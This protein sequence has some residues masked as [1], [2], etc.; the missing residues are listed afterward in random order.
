ME[1]MGG[2]GG[3]LSEYVVEKL[4]RD[5]IVTSIWEG[6][7]NIQ[8][9][10]F[11]EVLPRVR[12]AIQEEVERVRDASDRA[13]SGNLKVALDSVM[14]TLYGAQESGTLQY[15]QK[16]IADGFARLMA[17]TYLY[18]AYT[19]TGGKAGQDGSRPLLQEELHRGARQPGLLTVHRPVRLDAAGKEGGVRPSAP[20]EHLLPE[21]LAPRGLPDQE[22]KRHHSHECYGGV[23][24]AMAE[25]HGQGYYAYEELEAS[26]EVPAECSH[27]AE[28]AAPCL[29]GGRVQA[30]RGRRRRNRPPLRSP[31]AQGGRTCP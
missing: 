5:A 4:H 1:L 18:D 8:A 26:S 23:R 20:P 2:R 19:D 30:A 6:T 11:M 31:A 16:Q 25:A 9:L 13:V 3:F 22:D 14:D 24:N 12:E 28:A 7:S 10:D 27:C 15:Y 17:L 21:A 29:G